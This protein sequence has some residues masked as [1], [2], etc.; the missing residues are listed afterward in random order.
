MNKTLL[1]KFL[2]RTYKKMRDYIFYIKRKPYINLIRNKI[3]KDTSIISSNCFAGRIMQDFHIQ[4]N[5]PTLGLYFMY[6]D[7]IEFLKHLDFYLT[8]AK[9]QFVEH[10]KYSV[11][12]ERRANCKHWYPIGLL[13]G[14]VEIHFLHYYS[15]EEAAE[16]WY[17]R[18]SRV[19]FENLIIIGMEQNLCTIDDIIAFDK[20]PYIY[21][22]IFTSHNIPL[23]SNLY[24]KEFNG[25]KNVG[26]PYKKGH[27]F[28][29]YLCKALM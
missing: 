14:K 13:N 19:N 4:Y 2:L 23:K 27:L 22:Y 26:D 21:K 25:S 3:P 18:A 17:R 8:K 5:S 29:K 15:E 28:Y 10:S 9:I 7:Y 11:G 24:M 20:L 6:P 12:D 1:Y 16:K